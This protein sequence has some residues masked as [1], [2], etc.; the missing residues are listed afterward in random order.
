MWRMRAKPSQAEAD[1]MADEGDSK[2]LTIVA[3]EIA[4]TLQ[5]AGARLVCIDFDATLVSIHT[6]GTWTRSAAELSAYV[7]SLFRE[8]IPLL[9]ASS[10]TH[11]AVVTFSPQ[12]QLVR[13]VLAHCFSPEVAARVIVRADD[14]SWALV[15]DDTCDFMPA[16][17]TSG[18]HL[19]RTYKLP[20]VISAALHAAQR[21]TDNPATAIRNR[22]TVLIDDDAVNIRVANESGMTGI[23]FDPE[24]VDAHVLCAHI[25]KLHVQSNKS[26]PPELPLGLAT[27][28][29]RASVVR[30]MTTPEGGGRRTPS[31]GSGGRSAKSRSRCTKQLQT[32]FN[33]CTPSP[34]MKLKSTVDMGRPRSKRASK[35]LRKSSRRIED[36]LHALHLP[37]PAAV[38]IENTDPNC[39]GDLV[40]IQIAPSADQLL[41]IDSAATASQPASVAVVAT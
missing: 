37:P 22:E 18:R 16:W 14:T 41:K 30:V 32:R 19:D 6:G 11:V 39:G 13:E 12:A 36:D 25:K 7:R 28:S 5:A 27:P 40:N 9:C 8:L 21:E 31:S 33:M 34:V 38:A 23:Y 24:G 26:A 4:A 1:A 15:H 20:F 17:Q 29:R 35:F 10:Q 3:A 2:S